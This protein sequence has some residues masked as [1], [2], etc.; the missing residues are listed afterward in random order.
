MK[1]FRKLN[2]RKGFSLLESM[3]AL[4][5][6]SILTVGIVT[7]TN[8]ASRIY[9]KSLFVSEGDILA[10]TIDTAL[11]DLLR[12]SSEIT[13]KKKG[14]EISFTNANYSIIQGH[15]FLKDGWLYINQ[16][17]TKLD[18]AEDAPVAVLLNNG[19]YSSMEISSFTLKYQDGVFSGTY[20]IK[21]KK[22]EALTKDYSFNFRT[23]S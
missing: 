17:D 23:L 5:I 22:D 12:F 10:A 14:D 18:F 21:S 3:A 16:T 13:V 11:S 8:A 19:T 7:C 9:Y 1:L 2:S 4:M 20:E 6:V 15:L